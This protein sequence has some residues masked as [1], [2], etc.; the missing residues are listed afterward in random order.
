MLNG[1]VN[2]LHSL[3]EVIQELVLGLEAVLEYLDNNA[4]KLFI[5]NGLHRHMHSNNLLN[6]RTWKKKVGMFTETHWL[7]T[8]PA[9]NSNTRGEWCDLIESSATPKIKTCVTPI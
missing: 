5:A 3:K 8:Q 4:L 9:I 2:R 6:L 1:K 7:K